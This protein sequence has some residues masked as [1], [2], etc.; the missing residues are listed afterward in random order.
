MPRKFKPKSKD[1]K[2]DKRLRKLEGAMQKKE[3]K[4]VLLY[5]GSQATTAGITPYS[6]CE[7]AQGND[8][9]NR[10]GDQLCPRKLAFTWFV[11][12][13]DAAAIG[14]ARIMV[15]RVNNSSG[16]V[17]AANLLD[18]SSGSATFGKPN[19]VYTHVNVGNS[20]ISS[21]QEY[22]ILYDSG[23][24][25]CHPLIA[26]A[27]GNHNEV[28]INKK[29]KLNPRKP[30][31]YTGTTAATAQYGKIFL[32]CIANVTTMVNGGQAELYFTD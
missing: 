12:N 10:E 6:L 11:Q 1:K 31:H 26:N 21:G 27:S 8:Y 28:I 3:L 20:L 9:N 29:L 22:D 7:V 14:H 30:V 4:Q 23:T 18:L 15:V 25:V 13:N 24:F 16:T 17:T 19:V 2:Q 32:L 5:Q